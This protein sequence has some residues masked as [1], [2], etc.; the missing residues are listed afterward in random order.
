M[1]SLANAQLQS[2]G[3]ISD[4]RHLKTNPDPWQHKQTSDPAGIGIAGEGAIWLTIGACPHEL[5]CPAGSESTPTPESPA[6]E[7]GVGGAP[8]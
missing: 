4:S 8:E 3:T 5:A 6:G 1:D 2:I 7:V